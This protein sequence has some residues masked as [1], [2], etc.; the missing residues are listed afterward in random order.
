MQSTGIRGTYQGKKLSQWAQSKNLRHVWAENVHAVLPI[1]SD[2]LGSM[3]GESAATLC[4]FE[5]C[6]AERRAEFF[7][8]DW[9][10]GAGK[11]TGASALVEALKRAFRR[12]DAC[13][14]L[15]VWQATEERATGLVSSKIWGPAGTGLPFDRRWECSHLR[16]L[17]LR[18]CRL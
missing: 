15:A 3:S 13:L 11:D 5:W 9:G 10:G 6:Q 17:Y 14:T 8:E 4:L 16:L 1:V 18:T 12:W 7:V 2:A